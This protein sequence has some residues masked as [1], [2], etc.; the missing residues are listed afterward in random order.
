MLLC[1]QDDA[2]EAD[3]LL[4]SAAGKV[5]SPTFLVFFFLYGRYRVAVGL[6]LFESRL[7]SSNFFFLYSGRCL[8]PYSASDRGFEV[9][10]CRVP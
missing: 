2:D 9:E 1:L 5:L 7:I 6:R 3:R 10:F 8:H 4:Y